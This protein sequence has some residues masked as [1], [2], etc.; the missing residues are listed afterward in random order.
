MSNPIENEMTA[1][2]L[3]KWMIAFGVTIAV[4]STWAVKAQ[5]K[6]NHM[7]MN[8]GFITSRMKETKEFYKHLL[9]F[10]IVFENNFYLLMR[11]PGS[12]DQ[13][14]FLLPDHETQQPLFKPAFDGRGAYLTIEVENV[15]G[16]FDRIKRLEIPIVIDL[17]SEPWGDRHFAIVDPNGI[18]IDIVTYTVPSE[19]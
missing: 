2:R 12:T 6:S 15:D 9:G 16:E 8:A 17:R 18:G 19:K 10:E 5:T 3:R 4:L 13:I 7:K 14:S 1:I 11:A